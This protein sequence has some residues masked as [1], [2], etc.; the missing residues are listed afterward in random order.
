MGVLVPACV[1]FGLSSTVVSVDCAR[2]GQGLGAGLLWVGSLVWLMT[3]TVGS[4]RG[5]LLGNTVGAALLGT[6]LGPV[7]GTAAVLVGVGSVFGLIAAVAVI[8][9]VRVWQ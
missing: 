9:G 5:A 1:A 6:L 4:D 7:L 2:A 3:A 8:M